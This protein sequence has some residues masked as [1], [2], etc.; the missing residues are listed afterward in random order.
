M[1]NA[2]PKPM[3]S[4]SPSIATGLIPPPPAKEASKLAA[5]KGEADSLIAA[6]PAESNNKQDE[7]KAEPLAK[8]NEAVAKLS[9]QLQ[10][11]VA[12]SEKFKTASG[13]KIHVQ[14]GKIT[15][16]IQ[17]TSDSA[18]N[19]KALKKLGF[20]LM[21]QERTKVVG[22]ISPDKLEELVKLKFVRQVKENK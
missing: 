22:K 14:D 17:L 3:A 5:D 13:L 6:R 20:E 11:L 2:M 19:I 16:E 7:K 10:K 8:A 21:L 1:M 12:S 9:A 15:I 4:P 18:E